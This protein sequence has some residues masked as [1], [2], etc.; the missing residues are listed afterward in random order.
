MISVCK[1]YPVS[2]IPECANSKRNFQIF[3]CEFWSGRSGL[4]MWRS[5]E[6]PQTHGL[7]DMLI[8]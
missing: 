2:K 7:I 4:M 3:L 6:I 1:S 8:R 5:E